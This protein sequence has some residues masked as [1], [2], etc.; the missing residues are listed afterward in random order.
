VS[1]ITIDGDTVVGDAD[2]RVSTT[3]AVGAG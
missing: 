1:T 2:P 3:A